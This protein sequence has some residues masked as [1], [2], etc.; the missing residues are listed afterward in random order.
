MMMLMGERGEVVQREAGY[1][2]ISTALG[3]AKEGQDRRRRCGE[4]LPALPS[5]LVGPPLS[6]PP[7]S[8]VHLA[9]HMAP[10][11]AKTG[12]GRR[13][14]NPRRQAPKACALPDCATPRWK[15]G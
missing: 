3:H 2:H 7:G 14:L 8:P 12:S 6:P 13:D 15:R 10:N 11:L 9:V 5:E 4:P 1:E